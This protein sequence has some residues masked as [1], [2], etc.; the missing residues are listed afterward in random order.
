L[1]PAQFFTRNVWKSYVDP[2]SATPAEAAWRGLAS[3]GVK[4]GALASFCSS[5]QYALDLQLLGG[6]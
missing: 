1:A 5:T 4:V 2:E 3:A 6:H